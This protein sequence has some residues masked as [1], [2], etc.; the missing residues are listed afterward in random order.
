MSF[1]SLGEVLGNRGWVEIP[2]RSFTR[3]V[4]LSQMVQPAQRWFLHVRTGVKMGLPGPL[5]G[6]LKDHLHGSRYPQSA[7]A[8]LPRDTRSSPITH[9]RG[10][11]SSA[12]EA[13]K[14]AG[15]EAEAVPSQRQLSGTKPVSAWRLLALLS[16]DF[17]PEATGPA[18]FGD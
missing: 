1:L 18:C 12:G 11:V 2:D 14:H 17:S 10:R 8:S 7:P 15:R 13:Q 3:R 5:G 16:K 9:A 6:E 4:P